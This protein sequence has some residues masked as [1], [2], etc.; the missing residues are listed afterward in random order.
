MPHFAS[1]QKSYL[2]NSVTDLQR[3]L[4]GVGL[5][6]V[7]VAEVLL[8]REVRNGGGHVFAIAS[9]RFE[10]ASPD[11][12]RPESRFSTVKIGDLAGY[13]EGRSSDLQECAV[14]KGMNWA[15]VG[16]RE[17]LTHIAEVGGEVTD[18][19]SADTKFTDL[20]ST[21]PRDTPL[22]G[23]VLGSE[24]ISWFNANIP[25]SESVPILWKALFEGL[26]GLAYCVTP[27]D[28]RVSVIITFE[29]ENPSAASA[30]GAVLQGV[31]A[32][33]GI[34]WKTEHPGVSDPFVDAEVTVEDRKVTLALS[35]SYQALESGVVLGTAH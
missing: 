13:C 2:D 24:A 26:D 27:G 35:P 11:S 5:S 21:I 33:E 14:F 4:G 22:W 6:E 29:Y 1:L 17:F 10:A 12:G 7:D 32:L 18:P 9:G 23:I 16:R 15:A 19:L 31:K 3:W 34:F 8:G 30:L 20:A 28:G 25:F